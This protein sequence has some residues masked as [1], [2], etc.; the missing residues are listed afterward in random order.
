[1]TAPPAPAAKR[2]RGRPPTHGFYSRAFKTEELA[3]IAPFLTDLSLDHELWM[4]RVLNLRLFRYASEAGDELPLAELVRVAEALTRG[5]GRVAR[6]LRDRRALSG[7][8]AD[9]ITGAIAQVLDEL[10]TE[11]GRA[12]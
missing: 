2:Q 5:A 12:L 7:E 8:A 9:G 10:S 1:V 4:Q 6:L 3:W 11:T